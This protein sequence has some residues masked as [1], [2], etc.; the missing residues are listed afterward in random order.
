[1]AFELNAVGLL[2]QSRKRIW[3]LF[4]YTP[5]L[6]SNIAED[7]LVGAYSSYLFKFI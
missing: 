1:M 4:D 5:K 3:D 6:S 7:L 2:V